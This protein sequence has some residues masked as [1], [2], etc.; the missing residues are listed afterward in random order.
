MTQASNP[1]TASLDTTGSIA[2]AIHAGKAMPNMNLKS[3]LTTVQMLVDSTG[4]LRVETPYHSWRLLMWGGSLALV[5]EEAELATTIVRK[6]RT[7]KLQVPQANLLTDN[8]RGIQLYEAINE[9]YLSQEEQV[10]PLLKEILFESLLAIY[11][12]TNFTATWHPLSH[13]PELKLPIWKF[14]VL[15]DVAKRAVQQ[16]KLLQHI[17]HPYQTVQLLDQASSIANLPLFAKVTNGK[18]RISEIADEFKQHISRTAQKLDKLAESRTVAILPLVFRQARTQDQETAPDDLEAKNIP[19]ILV[20]D[21]SPIQLK[22]FGELLQS[23]GYRTH[24]ISDPYT[25]RQVMLERKPS[26][27]FMDINMPGISGFELIK[28]IRREAS[29]K[30]TPLVLI[31]SADNMANKFRA[32]WAH[33]KFL[34]KAKSNDDLHVQEFRNQL[35]EIL[36]ETAPLPT[37]A[38]V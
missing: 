35:R 38:L 14:A 28:E 36:R 29:L 22:Q 3:L 11:L 23:W 20:V 13:V 21:D 7:H 4:V 33:C 30:D 2:K 24:L 12:E 15:D 16:W 6:L 37:D 19:Q 25:V 1:T 18:F 10:R 27:V 9:I 8:L 31:T 34:P 5:D 17:R 26:L 32:N